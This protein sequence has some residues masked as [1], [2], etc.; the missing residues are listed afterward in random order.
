VEFGA[1]TGGEALR[2]SFGEECSLIGVREY[3]LS[4]VGFA[5]F[6]VDS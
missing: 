2:E 5:D 1:D 6:D 3:V 4:F